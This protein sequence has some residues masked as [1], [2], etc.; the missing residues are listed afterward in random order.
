MANFD[1]KSTKVPK[2]SLE[3]LRHRNG[4]EA[5]QADEF[6]PPWDAIISVIANVE[7]WLNG[8][9]SIRPNRPFVFRKIIATRGCPIWLKSPALEETG[10]DKEGSGGFVFEDS[11][12]PNWEHSR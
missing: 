10:S 6:L 11:E 8:F 12:K 1:G 9:L 5:E 7:R 2:E 4:N 3:G